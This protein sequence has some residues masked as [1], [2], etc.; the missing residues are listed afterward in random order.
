MSSASEDSESF[1]ERTIRKRKKQPDKWKQNNR[2]NARL[3]GEEYVNTVGN[4]VSKK[5]ITEIE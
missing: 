1:T 3:H 2:K 5:T 4:T